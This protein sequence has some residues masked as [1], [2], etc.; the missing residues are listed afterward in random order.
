VGA[1]LGS[2]MPIA[3]VPG[4]IALLLFIMTR[5]EDSLSVSRPRAR[6]IFQPRIQA[7]PMVE[8]EALGSRVAI[9]PTGADAVPDDRDGRSATEVAPSTVQAEAERNAVMSTRSDIGS[10]APIASTGQAPLQ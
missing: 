7:I 2:L 9:Q 6:R 4:G 3:L 1:L 10:G 8:G 5:L